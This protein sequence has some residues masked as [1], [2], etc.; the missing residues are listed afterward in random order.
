MSGAHSVAFTLGRGSGETW[1]YNGSYVPIVYMQDYKPTNMKQYHL[2]TGIS[3]YSTSI[4]ASSTTTSPHSTRQFQSSEFVSCVAMLQG[5]DL[6]SRCTF[7]ATP[8]AQKPIVLM[9]WRLIYSHSAGWVK[10]LI[11]HQSVRNWMSFIRTSI[12][13]SSVSNDDSWLSF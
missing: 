8:S 11:Q 9:S 3:L 13:S 7:P 1:W 6:I 12:S 4:K 2:S 10:I 5:T